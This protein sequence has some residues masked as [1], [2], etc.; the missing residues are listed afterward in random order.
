[1]TRKK[2]II[3]CGLLPPPVHG[4]SEI[5]NRVLQLLR[6]QGETVLTY[7]SRGSDDRMGQ[8]K[9][10]LLDLVRIAG[11]MVRFS[12]S[13]MYIG[14]SGGSGKLVDCLFIMMA[15]IFGIEVFIH[16]HSFR[17][18]NEFERSA[19]LAFKIA[20]NA[21]HV[22]LCAEMGEI[23]AM[24]YGI[25]ASKFLTIP[26][27]AFLDPLP[28][29]VPKRSRDYDVAPLN[30]GFLSNITAEK[31]IFLFL[32]VL[33]RFKENASVHAIVA[34][35]VEKQIEEEFSRRVKEM[36]N[37]RYVGAV[38]GEE[39]RKFFSDIDILLF[40][41]RYR[42]EAEPVTILE[43]LAHGVPVIGTLRG[44]IATIVKENYGMVA[45]ETEFTA[46]ASAFIES[47]ITNESPLPIMSTAAME[48]F[49]DLAG[50]GRLRLGQLIKNLAN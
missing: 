10:I 11:D 34:G 4:F 3:F 2:V 43:A 14:L 12:P 25:K 41:S 29:L 20:R 8:V 7:R 21:T 17:Y 50:I 45:K 39:K 40:P 30:I 32:D 1:M 18:V 33:E 49:Q 6:K 48:S 35:P 44:C 22:T 28:S 24:R 36:P 16:H 37:V 46:V 13:S 5:N 47:S 19:W 15:R 27:A 9:S 42:N 31:G 23:L 38:Y 26:N